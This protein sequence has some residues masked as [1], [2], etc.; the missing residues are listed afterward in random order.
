MVHR[1]ARGRPGLFVSAFLVPLALSIVPCG[2]GGVC[3]AGPAPTPTPQG[4]P[5]AAP[6]RKTLQETVTERV[7]ALKSDK[8]AVRRAAAMALGKI[9]KRV[10]GASASDAT[11]RDTIVSSLKG[12]LGDTDQNV[13]SMGAWALGNMGAAAQDAIPLLMDRVDKDAFFEVRA[14]AAY[15]LGYMGSAAQDAV[16]ML[17]I[18]V[19][20]DG[21]VKVRAESARTLGEIGAGL[22]GSD[23]A[24]GRMKRDILATLQEV[25]GNG[26]EDPKVRGMAAIALVRMG[27]ARKDVVAILID[28]LAK[29]DDFEIRAE[30]AYALGSL[31][32]VAQDALPT[33]IDRVLKDGHG[34]V[35]AVI[36]GALGEIGSDLKGS[37]QAVQ[38]KEPIVQALKGALADKDFEVL[39]SATEALGRLCSGLKLKGGGEKEAKVKG[40]IVQIL[41]AALGSKDSLVRA[42]A[43]WTLGELGAEL[44]G[45]E[46]PVQRMRDMILQVLKDV[47]DK[48]DEHPEVRK[49]ASEAVEKIKGDPSGPDG[50]KGRERWDRRKIYLWGGGDVIE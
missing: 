16:P 21:H 43:A 47:A 5:P 42:T 7:G 19:M 17:R 32:I 29:D 31:G 11:I 18:H 41:I 49:A 8:P 48:E 39:L 44:K 3:A 34:E 40:D 14:E 38:A 13:R 23:E 46:E 2:G 15:A 12:A 30:S 26:Q 4:T 36:A 24:A 6:V 1:D 25:W 27:V 33:M 45:P 35:R 10:K 50:S 28:R 20:K 22:K 9:G 37:P